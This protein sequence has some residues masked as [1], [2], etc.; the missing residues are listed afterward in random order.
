MRDPYLILGVPDDADDA[1][2]EAAYLAGIKRCT[3]ERDADGFQALRAA[4]EALRTQRDRLA[5]ALF[6]TAP[7]EPADLLDRA[8][9][10]ERAPRPEEAA[11]TRPEPALFAA[12]LRGDD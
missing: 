8:F 6:E 1:A 12:L 2:I 11:R 5:Y 10:L 3:P 7:P 4:Y 9:P